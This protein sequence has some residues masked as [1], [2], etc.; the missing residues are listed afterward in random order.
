[1]ISIEDIKK[2]RIID[3]FINMANL[4]LTNMG[5][6]E[7]GHRHANLV[8]NM[9]K[10]VLRFLDYSE[11]EQELAAIAGYIHDIGNV[12]SR[13]GHGQT[14]AILCF[15]ILSDMG[16]PADEVA[17][18]IGAIGNHEESYGH[19]VNNVSAALIL[20]DKS[21]VH[22]TRVRN[23]DA[24]TFDIHDRVNYAVE[25]SALII[26]KEERSVT[27]DLSIQS[28]ICPVMEY[29]EIFLTRMIMCRRAAEFLDTK[30]KI[31]INGAKM[32]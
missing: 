2:N 14:S 18:I 21:D 9:A 29:F 24:A 13:E 4:H 11:R 19:P 25:R 10:N 16:M 26:N 3:T 22:R 7:H 28:E 15:G 23:R 1:M 6:T 30:F 27:L 31:E 5:F 12:V 20:A 32:L 8:S 17:T